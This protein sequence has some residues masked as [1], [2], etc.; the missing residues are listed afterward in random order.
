MTAAALAPELT[1]M[2]DRLVAD[3]RA[4]SSDHWRGVAIY[5]GL[6]KG[7]YTPGIS[8]INLLV[9]LDQTDFRTLTALAEVLTPARRRDRVAALVLTPGELEE[10]GR[11]FPVKL[12]DIQAAHRVLAG[13]PGIAAVRI[14]PVAF[15]LRLRQEMRNLEL[16]FRQT[17]L[18]RGAE[19][20][21]LWRRL[22]AT[23]PRLAVGLEAILRHRGAEAPRRRG[24][25]LRTA[26]AALEVPPERVEPFATIHRTDPTPPDDRVRDLAADYLV[27]LHLLADRMESTS[28]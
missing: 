12:A 6:A 10:F 19:P 18:E 13:E 8:D 28:S 2:L 20:A 15:G 5:G 23:L 9:I 11:L 3:L 25:I 27:L 24:D 4:A 16:R 21:V 22:T 14:D 26:A 1:A 7:R 17:V